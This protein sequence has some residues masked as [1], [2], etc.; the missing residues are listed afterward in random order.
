MRKKLKYLLQH[1]DLKN[2]E[3]T[4]YLALLKLQEASI[5][6][7]IEA[8]KLSMMMVYRTINRLKEKGLVDSIPLN[9]K[10]NIYKPL[11]LRSLITKIYSKQR[12]LARLAK[13]LKDLDPFLPWI[14]ENEEKDEMIEVREGI[15]AFKEEYLK[16]PDHCRN[17]YL[18]IGN[19]KNL[20][21]LAGWDYECPEE[22]SF[23]R[24]RLN[25]GVY[26]RVLNPPYK[27]AEDIM[28]KDSVEKRTFKL[29]YNLPVT[30][31]YFAL[32][33]KHSSLFICD[34]EDPRVVIVRQPELLQIQRDQFSSLWAK[35]L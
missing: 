15:D 5:T 29:H 30:N 21:D 6:Q 1:S 20:W 8:S 4:V 22:R 25:R 34:P 9:D 35:S 32:A 33:D 31:N 28:K 17:E 18:H 26:A 2:E 23:I 24:R 14:E 19:M 10:Q 7:L 16:L 11:S 27:G 12:K 3:I 13:G